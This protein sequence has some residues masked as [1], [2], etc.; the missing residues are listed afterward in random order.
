MLCWG[1]YWNFFMLSTMSSSSICCKKSYHHGD[2]LL[3]WLTPFLSPLF[4]LYSILVSSFYLSVNIVVLYQF[5]LKREVSRSDKQF[6]IAIISRRRSEED[7]LFQ[8]FYYLNAWN[9]LQRIKEWIFERRCQVSDCLHFLAEYLDLNPYP[10]ATTVYARS[11]F[12]TRPAFYS[13]SAC[14]SLRFTLSLHLTLVRS[15]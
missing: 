13:Q 2:L 4:L 1:N 10:F 11:A 15:P 8:A 6:K 14:C 5:N 12:F 7:S 9:R 3:E